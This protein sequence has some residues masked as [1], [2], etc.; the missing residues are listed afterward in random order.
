MSFARTPK[1][2]E[3][4]DLNSPV[5]RRDVVNLLT[6]RSL[7]IQAKRCRVYAKFRYSLNVKIFVGCADRATSYD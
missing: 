1:S 5:A 2:E 6:I 7:P 3:A 4:A